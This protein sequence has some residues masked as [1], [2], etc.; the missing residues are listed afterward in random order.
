[1]TNLILEEGFEEN[2]IKEYWKILN[3]VSVFVFESFCRK[4]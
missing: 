4:L 1:M 2:E 3:F